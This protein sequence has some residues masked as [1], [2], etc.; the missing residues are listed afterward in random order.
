MFQTANLHIISL[1]VNACLLYFCSSYINAYFCAYWTVGKIT[2]IRKWA[3][4]DE[5]SRAIMHMTGKI[6]AEQFK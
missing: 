6:V 1:N 5:K 2:L 3:I 4:L